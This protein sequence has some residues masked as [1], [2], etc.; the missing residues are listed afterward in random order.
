M[1]EKQ[2]DSDEAPTLSSAKMERIASASGGSLQCTCTR[3][4]VGNDVFRD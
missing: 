4:C 2:N 1:K 3:D